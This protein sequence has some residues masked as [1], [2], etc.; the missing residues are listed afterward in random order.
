MSVQPEIT[1]KRLLLRPFVIADA[2]IV[3]LLAGH[4]KIADTTANIPHPYLDGLAEQWIARHEPNWDSGVLCSYAITI[5]ESNVLIGAI[6][7]MN[8]SQQSGELGYWIGVDYWGKGYCSEACAA[9]VHFGFNRLALTRIHAHHLSRNPASGKV[10]LNSGL[11]H[12]GQDSITWPR[13]GDT[14]SIERYETTK[15]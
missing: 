12:K 5:I 15:A 13:T 11:L 10:L 4:A 3:Q 2:P 1:T 6:S 7:L 14:E 8:I 9:L